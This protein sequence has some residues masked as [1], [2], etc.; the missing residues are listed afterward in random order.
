VNRATPLS[1]LPEFLTVAE[2]AAY[3]RIGKGLIYEMVRSGELR[4]VRMGRLV[5]VPREAL[6]EMAG[7]RRGAA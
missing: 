1:E 2:V 4:S 6:S 3:L 5:R 7:E